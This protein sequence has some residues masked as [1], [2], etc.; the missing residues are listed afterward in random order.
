MFG[1][2]TV[3]RTAATCFAVV[4]LCVACFAQIGETRTN[5]DDLKAIRASLDRLVQLTQDL[6]KSQ[7]AILAIQQ[8]QLYELKL[9]SLETRDNALGE[10]EAELSAQNANLEKAAR[11]IESGGI[12]PTG[13]P[14][15]STDSGLRKEATEQLDAN[16]RLLASTRS[17]K[18]QG[19]RDIALAHPD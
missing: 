11:G 19:T 6:D 18:Q 13:V 8:M 15:T 16:R 10:R 1:F 17:K 2:Q 7:K 5:S 9:Q 3:Q 14:G 12:S 4:F